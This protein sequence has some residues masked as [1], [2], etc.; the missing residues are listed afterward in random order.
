M[1]DYSTSAGRNVGHCH[2]GPPTAACPCHESDWDEAELSPEEA[3]LWDDFPK[4]EQIKGPT[5]KYNCHGYAYTHSHGW[6]CRP[7]YFIADD[8]VEVDMNKA[9]VGDVLIYKK[10]E[11][12]FVRHSARVKEAVGGEIRKCRS[13]W[14][15]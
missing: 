8:F 3:A 5:R 4:L 2:I 9:R 12:D 10:F 1:A 13:K 7:D 15:E 6:F 11:E 14:G